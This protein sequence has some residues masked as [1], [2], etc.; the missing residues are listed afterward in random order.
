[1][2]NFCECL[3]HN[4]L[5]TAKGLV[6][7][8]QREDALGI[9]PWVDDDECYLYLD[10]PISVSGLRRDETHHVFDDRVLDEQYRRFHDDS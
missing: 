8:A 7:A 3:S 9:G 2:K 6:E 5:L 4:G 10:L 1:M